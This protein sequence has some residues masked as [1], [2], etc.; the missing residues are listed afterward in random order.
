MSELELQ[1]AILKNALELERLSANDQADAMRIMAALERDLKTLLAQRDLSN[2]KRREIEAI[3]NEA[4]KAIDGRYSALGGVVDTRGLMLVVSQQTVEAIR[5][6]GAIRALTP[7]RIASLAKT[8]LIE[9]APSAAWWVKQ[10]ERLQFDFARIVREGVIDGATQE[11]ITARIIG[12]GDEPGIMDAARRNVRSLVHSSIMTAANRA[13][14]E[15]FANNSRHLAGV[16]WLATL[17]SHTC[18]TCMALDGRVWDLEGNPVDQGEDAMDFQLPPAHFACRCTMSPVAKSLDAILGV[19]GLDAK[20]AAG[21][22]RASKDGPTSALTFSEFLR[23]QSPEYIEE[24]LGAERAALWRQGK[25]TLR[26][27]VSGSGRELT[28]EQ[29]KQRMKEN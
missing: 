7:E 3:L 16:R 2:A 19:K 11:Q 18:R 9:G 22:R 10:S 5:T 27:L 21:R 17:D 24:A 26:D 1:E 15:T 12:T 14:L 20:L 13:R 29:I 4:K 8:V 25:V 28:L 6:L 23:R